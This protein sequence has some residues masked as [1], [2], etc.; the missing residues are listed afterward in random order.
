MK[1]TGALTA[2]AEHGKPGAVK[3]LL[4][5]RERTGDFDL[6][7]LEEYGSYD[8]RKQDDHGTA[9]YKAA[10]EGHSEIVDILLDKGADPRFK[11]T[12]GRSVADVAE[13]GGHEELA[14]RVKQLI[15]E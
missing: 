7:E 4:A 15:I 3:L 9:L 2:A 6:E 8:H 11:D 14:R 5:H 1:G 10:G 13:M 12:K